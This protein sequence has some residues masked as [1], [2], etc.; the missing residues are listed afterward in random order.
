MTKSTTNLPPT[1]T[2]SIP[3]PISSPT[4]SSTTTKASFLPEEINTEAPGLDYTV[5]HH[6][7]AK[8]LAIII[9]T[10]VIYKLIK[11][12]LLK[13]LVLIFFLEIL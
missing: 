9:A 1:T 2:S 5:E 8:I 12:Y 4:T 13:K 7:V 10:V 3:A 11:V 6:H